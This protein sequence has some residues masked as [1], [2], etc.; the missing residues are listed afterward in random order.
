MAVMLA[1]TSRG[2]AARAKIH[3][4]EIP[5][6]HELLDRAPRASR[7]RAAARRG[8]P[9][10]AA[11]TSSAGRCAT[12][13]WSGSRW[14]STWS[15]RAIADA[16]PRGLGAGRAVHDR[17]GT[18]RSRSAGS[19][20]TS[21][22][23]GA[24]PTR[25]P[26]RCPRSSPAGL[27]ED[28]RRRDFT[29][30]ALARRARRGAAGRARGGRRTALEDL[31]ARRAAGASRAEL[32]RRSDAAA[33]AGALRQRGW[34]SPSSPHTRELAGDGADAGAL[35]RSAGRAWAPSCACWP[36]SRTPWP[37]SGALDE[38]GLARAHRPGLRPAATRRW[39]SARLRCCPPDGRRERA[40]AR[41]WRR[42]RAGR[43][44][45]APCSTRWR[46][47]RGPR[48]H[49]RA[50][51]GAPGRGRCAGAGARA[52]RDRRAVGRRVAGA[53]RARRCP[54][55]GRRGARVAGAA[56]ATSG[57]RSTASDLLA[58]GVRQGPA[59]GRGLRAALA[60]KLDGRAPIGKPSSP[61]ALRGSRGQRIAC[62][63]ARAPN[64]CSGTAQPGHY[65]VYYLTLTDPARGRCLDP[66]HDAG[67]AFDAE[68]PT[69]ARC[70]FWR[71]IPAGQPRR[72][73]ARR[74]FRSPSC[75]RR[76]IRSSSV[77]AKPR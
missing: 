4:V 44:A 58:A 5:P 8:S 39:P 63:D 11:C 59:V 21:P 29:V 36:A 38:L 54:R 50:A 42:A 24:R 55:A 13:C 10:R 45:W 30:N 51:M 34:A 17:F 20:T 65:E 41:R 69:A 61:S 66:V 9:E 43:R 27:A 70:G 28:L 6:P 23:P 2:G 74:A 37:R 22:R 60:A 1:P 19:A 77:S 40:R 25:G 7:G 46:S 57:S 26:V 68:A 3:R 73:R 31:D 15:S 14:S 35:A 16:S 52:V 76:A 67:A 64:R 33:A 48:R 47:R 75:A 12:C 56:C 62:A 71:W 49:P 72:S 18:A 32:C 53:G